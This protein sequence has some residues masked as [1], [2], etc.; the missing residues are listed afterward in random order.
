[1]PRAAKIGASKSELNEMSG[2]GH[3]HLP[4]RNKFFAVSPTPIRDH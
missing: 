2:D 1:M 4:C 3:A